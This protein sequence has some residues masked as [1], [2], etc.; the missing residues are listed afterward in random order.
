M[1]GPTG[2]D[3]MAAVEVAK[4]MDVPIDQMFFEKLK[5]YEMTVLEHMR[6]RGK[7]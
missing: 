2:F 7:E 5:A 6:N 4:A 3:F 1:A